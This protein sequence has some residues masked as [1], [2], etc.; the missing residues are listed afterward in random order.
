MAEENKVVELNDKELDKVSGGADASGGA[1]AP[2]PVNDISQ[3]VR[4]NFYT[5]G[6]QKTPIYRVDAIWGTMI[7]CGIYNYDSTT[8][9]ATNTRGSTTNYGVGTLIPR[10]TP[11][12]V[13]VDP[14]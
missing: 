2:A 5:I 10:D 9:T 6:T 7:V 4:Y 13:I 12:Y 8:D 11:T 1:K 3:I 14:K